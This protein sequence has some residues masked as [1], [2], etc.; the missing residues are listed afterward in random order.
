MYLDFGAGVFP[1]PY[2]SNAG[3]KESTISYLPMPGRILISRFTADN[4]ASIS[5]STLIQYRYVII[6]GSVN[7]GLNNHVNLKDYEAVRKFYRIPD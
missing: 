7:I 3:G 6:P 2:T 1:M 4:S 5:L